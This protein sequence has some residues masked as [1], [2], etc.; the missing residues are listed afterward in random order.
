MGLYLCGG[1]DRKHLYGDGRGGGCWESPGKP[2][3]VELGN[4]LEN[5]LY[6]GHGVLKNLELLEGGTRPTL[7]LHPPQP[8]LMPCILVRVVLLLLDTYSSSSSSLSSHANRT[9]F[10]TLEPLFSCEGVFSKNKS[11]AGLPIFS[12]TCINIVGTMSPIIVVV[13]FSESILTEVTPN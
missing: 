9:L 3:H 11:S 6:A 2:C 4:G 10:L 13:P 5:D 7:L 12:N 8:C 1:L